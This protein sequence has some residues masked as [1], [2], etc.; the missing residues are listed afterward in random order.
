M[1]AKSFD[2]VGESLR[3]RSY[4]CR[5]RVEQLSQ[6][7]GK[8]APAEIARIMNCSEQAVK[9]LA[10]RNHISLAIQVKPW[11]EREK[12][13]VRD[14]AATM[15][16]R[17][18]AATLERT[19]HSVKAFAQANSISLMKRGENHWACKVSDEDVELIR[20]L[21]EANVKPKVIAEKMDLKWGHVR[22]IVYYNSR[23]GSIE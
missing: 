16:V 2:G 10:Q 1:S 19:K 23:R 21:H 4:K 14:N 13:F 7:A 17:E 20:S 22:S 8:L 6:Y 18:I 9:C 5:T 3:R 11:T 12:Q 15:P